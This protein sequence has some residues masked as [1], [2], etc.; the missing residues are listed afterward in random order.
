MATMFF[1]HAQRVLVQYPVAGFAP[2]KDHDHGDTGSVTDTDSVPA[3][4]G[5]SGDIAGRKL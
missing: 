2:G 5:S 3:G 1:T 4:A